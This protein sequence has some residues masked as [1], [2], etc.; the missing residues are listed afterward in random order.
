MGYPVIR[1]WIRKYFEDHPNKAIWKDDLIEACTKIS[2]R[3]HSVEGVRAAIKHL[4]D[5]GMAIQVVEPNHCWVYKPELQQQ[6]EQK[7]EP[8]VEEKLTEEPSKK[9][10]NQIFQLIHT[11][12]QGA[13]ILE[14]EDGD[15]IIVKPVDI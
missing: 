2:G 4:I 8:Q 12:K 5:N 9:Y 13:M 7:P 6:P 10:R 14:D 11:T 3:A 1:P 15:T